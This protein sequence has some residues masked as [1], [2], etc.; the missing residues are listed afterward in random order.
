MV[1]AAMVTEIM[2]GFSAQGALFYVK[3]LPPIFPRSLRTWR[4]CELH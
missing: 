1:C 4:F 2:Q 3:P